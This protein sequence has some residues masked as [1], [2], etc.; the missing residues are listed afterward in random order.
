M[1]GIYG[2]EIMMNMV[3][4][5]NIDNNILI[6]FNNNKWSLAHLECGYLN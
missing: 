2:A 4:V 5:N 3:I 6:I 1:T